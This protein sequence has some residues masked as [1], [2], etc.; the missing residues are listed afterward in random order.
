METVKIE[1]TRREAQGKSVARRLRANGQIPAVAYGRG[2]PA[3]AVAVEPKDVLHVLGAE[4]G[5]NS[6]IELTVDGKDKMTVLLTDY[7]YHPVSRELLHADFYRISLDEPVEVEVPLELTG[8]PKGVV[9]GGVLRQV[10]RRLPIRC[11]PKDIPAKIV[12]DVTELD[13]DD[14]V[15]TT[16]L[17]LGEGVAVQLPPTQTVAAVVTEKKRGPEEEEAAAGAAAAAP[18]AAPAAADAKPAESK[19]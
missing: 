18:G 4:R 12:H 2:G 19:D 17:Q 6:V 15:R 8:K 9:M 11:L 13:M 5:R 3:Q 14:H 7:Q 16:D 10:F 1:A